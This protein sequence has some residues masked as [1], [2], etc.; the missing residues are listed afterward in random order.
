MFYAIGEWF[1]ERAADKARNSIK[2]LVDL[3]PDMVT[4]VREN[5]ISR[6]TPQEVEVGAVIEVVS[7]ERISLDGTLINDVAT[8]DTAALTGESEPTY[9]KLKER[10]CWPE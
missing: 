5:E 9:Y 8:F 7:G 10:K 6:I 2:S 4:L 1:Q 3:R